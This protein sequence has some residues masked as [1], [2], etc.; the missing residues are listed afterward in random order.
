LFPAK[1]EDCCSIVHFKS[2]AAFSASD[3]D[4]SISA[5][6]SACSLLYLSSVRVVPSSIS[7]SPVSKAAPSETGFI[8]S[9]LFIVELSKLVVTLEGVAESVLSLVTRFQPVVVT[10]LD[11]NSLAT[12]STQYCFTASTSFF[13]LSFVSFISAIF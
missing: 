6:L 11:F 4:L 7:Q 1:E 3:L 12:L 8:F 9:G 2:S 13:L 5:C 10:H